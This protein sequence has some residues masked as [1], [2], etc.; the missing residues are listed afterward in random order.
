VR[1]PLP[2]SIPIDD[3][4]NL[5]LDRPLRFDPAEDTDMFLI[6]KKLIIICTGDATVAHPER[7]PAP[8]ARRPCPGPTAAGE[9]CEP[10]NNAPSF[11]THIDFLLMLATS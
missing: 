3:Q 5:N 4:F 6:S 10:V 2:P 8:W 1:R 11:K 7:F 9:L